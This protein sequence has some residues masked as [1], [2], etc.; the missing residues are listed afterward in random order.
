MAL[1]YTTIGINWVDNIQFDYVGYVDRHHYNNLGINP[2]STII[3][4]DK[5]EIRD[6][7]ER[8]NETRWCFTHDYILRWLKGKCKEVILIGAA[9]F[10][11]K[12][13]YN[14]H[15]AAQ[16]CELNIKQSIYFIENEA[17][18]WYN[19]YKA[20]PNGILNIPIWKETICH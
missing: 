11:E 15:T 9:D 5:N 13:H 3:T 10:A 6:P 18:K 14:G 2:K 17:T 12:G 4:M 20:N 8:F 19:I 1:G 7:Y 16:P